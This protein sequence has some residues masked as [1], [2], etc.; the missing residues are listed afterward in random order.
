MLA[1]AVDPSPIFVAGK[2]ECMNCRSRDISYYAY[3]DDAKCSTCGQWQNE[4]RL[5]D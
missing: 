3:L 2:C 5:P 4:D 1:G